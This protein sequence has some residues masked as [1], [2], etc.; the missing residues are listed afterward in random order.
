MGQVKTSSA[1]RKPK[2]A[3]L[4]SVQKTFFLESDQVRPSC[5]LKD[6]EMPAQLSRWRQLIVRLEKV[7]E[8][9][10]DLGLAIGQFFEG[11][12]VLVRRHLSSLTPLRQVVKIK[13]DI[14]RSPR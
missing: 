6:S 7:D 9:S 12:S 14:R 1:T 13:R 3:E 10:V 4:V 5:I 11:W 8:V 2:A